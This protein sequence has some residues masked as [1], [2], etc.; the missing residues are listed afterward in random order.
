MQIS[1][2][3]WAHTQRLPLPRPSPSQLGHRWVCP[4]LPISRQH[5]LSSTAACSHPS[6][7]CV[8]AKNTAGTGDTRDCSEPSPAPRRF[9]STRLG[10][11]HERQTPI[12]N[13]RSYSRNHHP[14]IEPHYGK[15][16]QNPVIPKQSSSPAERSSSKGL[17]EETGATRAWPARE[18]GERTF[19]QIPSAH[20]WV[21]TGRWGVKG[22]VGSG[23]HR[24][25]ISTGHSWEAWF[26]QG[27][28]EQTT[29]SV[30]RCPR[31]PLS[32]PPS[33]Q[34]PKV[35]FQ[36]C[37]SKSTRLKRLLTGTRSPPATKLPAAGS[38]QR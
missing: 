22:E 21:D 24:G 1:S 34:A 35:T 8:M 36:H 33:L 25:S 12:N 37:C 13:G 20:P 18:R 2:R 30:S 19:A 5:L 9:K 3:R 26:T 32:C 15:C 11:D 31:D 6:S 38:T 7:P 27:T 14:L 29:D 17:E 16:V 23:T 4:S 28:L 10:S